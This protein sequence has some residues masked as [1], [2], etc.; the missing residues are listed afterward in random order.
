MLLR[1]VP[2]PP[3]AGSIMTAFTNP[4]W[5]VNLANAMVVAHLGPAYQVGA[6]LIGGRW[7]RAGAGGISAAGRA[8]AL[9]PA[10]HGGSRGAAGTP[11][12][13][14]VARRWPR[15]TALLTLHLR[16]AAAPHLLRSASSR[17]SCFWRPASRPGRAT[18]DGTGRA[19]GWAES[20]GRAPRARGLGATGPVPT[21][22]RGRA[23]RLAR[24]TRLP[25][26]LPPPPGLCVPAGPGAAPVVPV[27][28]GDVPHLP[29]LP[30][31]LLRLHHRPQRRPE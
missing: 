28:H 13:I 18:R 3:L 8:A 25:L 12:A 14:G 24:L 5:L 26:A 6:G 22:A 29:G 7:S 4:G 11:R 20:G 21:A 31:A 30:H 17:P 15:Q 19:S 9:V 2:A 16:L 1:A 27:P 23:D 10:S